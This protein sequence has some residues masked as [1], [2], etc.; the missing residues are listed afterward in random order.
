MGLVAQ[1]VCLLSVVLGPLSWQAARQGAF[2]TA[3]AQ[4]TD[5]VLWVGV[6]ERGVQRYDPA[7]PTAE[8]WRL[9]T[10]ADGLGDNYAYA[11]CVDRQNRV[12]V[13]HL[14][15]GVSVYDGHTWR[16]Y[17]RPTGPLG[18]RVFDL[19]LGPDG[20][21]WCGT[22]NGVARY[23]DHWRYA[24]RANGLPSD[25]VS[26]LAFDRHGRVLVGTQCDGIGRGLGELPRLG[27]PLHLPDAALGEGLPSP[28][29]NDLLTARDGT[30]Y[31][32]TPHGLA[33][34]RDDGATWTFRRGPEWRSFCEQAF[35]PVIPRE[36]EVTGDLLLEDYVT[37][38]AEDDAGLLWVGHRQW[39]YE[40][41]DPTTWRRVHSSDAEPGR[42]KPN[43]SKLYG[44]VPGDYVRCILPRPGEP[45]LIGWYGGPGLTVAGKSFATTEPP[46]PTPLAEPGPLPEPAAPPGTD[47]L[48][49]LAQRLAV[50]H[51]ELWPGEAV[52]L[53]EDWE[54]QGDW[55]GRLGRQY[56]LL[57]AMQ[58][59]LNHTLSFGRDYHVK[60][61]L[62]PHISKGDSLR[63]W[64]HRLTTDDRRTLYSPVVGHRRQA[65]WDDHGETYFNTWEGPDLWIEVT[66]PA[67]VHRLSLYFFNKDGHEHVNRNRDYLVE[68]R[69]YLA[70]LSDSA[71]QPVLA[72]C[73]VRDFRGGVYPQFLL[74][75]PARY[76]VRIARGQ[77][78]N[79]ILS[80]IFLDRLAGASTPLDQL[81]R[82]WLGNLRYGP[83]DAAQCA[84]CPGH[85]PPPIEGLPGELW[86]ALDAALVQ[87]DALSLQGLR[88][89]VYRA[90]LD[91]PAAALEPW[92]WRLGYWSESEREE[93]T[94]AMARSWEAMC[95]LNPALV[96]GGS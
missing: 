50:C 46:A 21:V 38:L 36:V 4:Q 31:A 90:A 55:V 17:D 58:S 13:G 39:G 93:F 89:L 76:H 9:F 83:F 79:T 47:D 32:A 35:L 19:Q 73:R 28:L 43:V 6:E 69:R 62:G 63:H 51:R 25:Q 80:G 22:D 27:S 77:S 1:T 70:D 34:S 64:V 3:L 2:V 91:Q 12:W 45:P 75:G 78:V 66:I 67:G 20:E 29:I 24:T 26:A 65:S 33:Y 18:E 48:Q 71:A 86:A 87:R 15:H 40:V 44:R 7:R 49:Q 54:T 10:A 88:G 92:R 61:G 68:L 72:H 74:R 60:G 84:T 52:Y 96:T 23:L 30:I 94:V 14:N 57:C 41:F 56:A 95:R 8:R 11:L 59:P 81:P 53:G 37:C 5:G 42:A 82:P 16:N 85:R